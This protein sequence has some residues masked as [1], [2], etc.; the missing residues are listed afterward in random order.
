[1]GQAAER[2]DIGAHVDHEHRMSG[3]RQSVGVYHDDERR[4]AVR[5]DGCDHLA[6]TEAVVRRVVDHEEVRQEAVL[7][8]V[9]E[10]FGALRL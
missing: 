7:V 3:I 9:G 8:R 2:I 4:G 10:H 6:G 5:R 1:M